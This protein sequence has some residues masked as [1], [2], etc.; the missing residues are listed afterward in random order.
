V[1]LAGGGNIASPE[2]GRN[3]YSCCRGSHQLTM[4]VRTG[5]FKRKFTKMLLICLISATD[6]HYKNEYFTENVEEFFLV[7]ALK[8][9]DRIV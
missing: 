2:R 3:S 5:F 4:P 7:S 9:L 8:R 6:W 1:P